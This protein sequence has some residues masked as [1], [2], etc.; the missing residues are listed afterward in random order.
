MAA[1]KSKIHAGSTQKFTE[2]VDVVDEVVILHGGNAC[3]VIEVQATNFTLLSVAEQEARIFAYASLLNSLS[4]PIQI[5]IRNKQIDISS[6]LQ[7][8]D[9]ESKK[10]LALQTQTIPGQAISSYINL[11]REY[12][13][14]LVKVNTVL[15]KKFYLVISYSYV[16]GGIRAS[17]KDFLPAAKASLQTKTNALIAQLSRLG[18]RS[19]VLSKESLIRLL[20][21]VYNANQSASIEVGS[22]TQT[23][24]ITSQQ[25]Q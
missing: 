2:V 6:Y 12:V 18:L 5:V 7:F 25:K 20:Y 15:D 3:S 17:S 16:E 19:Q 22:G 14:E 9:A 4:F 11:Y 1:Q 13:Q 10:A 8:L 23:S 21:D 24:V